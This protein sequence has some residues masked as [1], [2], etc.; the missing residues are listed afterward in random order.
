MLGQF[1]GRFHGF[2]SVADI[3]EVAD[4]SRGYARHQVGEPDRGERGELH[5][6]E[7]AEFHHLVIGRP[8]EFLAAVPDVDGPGDAGDEVEV[9]LP[10]LVEDA[11]PFPLDDDRNP[12]FH[13]FRGVLHRIRCVGFSMFDFLRQQNDRSD[14]GVMLRPRLP[15]SVPS[16]ST[17]SCG[18]CEEPVWEKASRSAFAKSRGVSAGCPGPWH[19]EKKAARLEDTRCRFLV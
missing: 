4:L 5:G 17:S 6:R 14:P 9:A 7:V 15:R 16:H 13:L 18:S 12:P 1:D 19:G 2:G 11:D 8:G 3:E 10:V